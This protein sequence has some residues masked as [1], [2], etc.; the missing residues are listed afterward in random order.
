MRSSP[1]ANRP[2]VPLCGT[3]RVE[4]HG[5][6]AH[7]DA[8]AQPRSEPVVYEH[9]QRLPHARN[10]REPVVE[11]ANIKQAW[12]GL[13]ERAQDGALSQVVVDHA[14]SIHEHT[15][16]TQEEPRPLGS[17]DVR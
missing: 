17:Q 1:V 2:R 8:I 12:M 6:A 10:V 7:A 14:P 4:A 9:A 13:E 15:F 5:G 11:L 3:E 16:A